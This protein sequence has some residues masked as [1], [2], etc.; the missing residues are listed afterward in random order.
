[1]RCINKDKKITMKE[2]LGVSFKFHQVYHISQLFQ[3]DL[4]S[5]KV[6]SESAISREPS[7]F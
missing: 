7:K 2:N 6:F 4:S 3:T 1:M 5:V